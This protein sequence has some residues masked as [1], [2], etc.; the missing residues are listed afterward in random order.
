MVVMS[1]FQGIVGMAQ[2][3]QRGFIPQN[4]QIL[5]IKRTDKRLHLLLD[6]C[7]RMSTCQFIEDRK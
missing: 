5:I 2:G 7:D 4:L 3:A 1:N 6:L